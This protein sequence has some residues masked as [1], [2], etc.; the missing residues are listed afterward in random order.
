[1]ENR[2]VEQVLSGVGA[3]GRGEDRRK[4]WRKINMVEYYV[5]MYENG[6]MRPVESSP[7]MEGTNKGW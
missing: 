5:L 4:E 1:M 7:G 3:G 6:N 2:R